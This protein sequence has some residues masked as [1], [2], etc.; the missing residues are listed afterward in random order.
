MLESLTESQKS[1]FPTYANKWI[2]FGNAPVARDFYNEAIIA[3][4]QNTV[5]GMYSI[6]KKNISANKVYLAGSPYHAAF[7]CAAL[8]VGKPGVPAAPKKAKLQNLGICEQYINS[9][10]NPEEIIKESKK[11]LGIRYW[12]RIYAGFYAML[13]FFRE[14]TELKNTVFKKYEREYVYGVLFSAFCYDGFFFKDFA[15][16]SKCPVIVAPDRLEWADGAI[17]KR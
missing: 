6:T 13:D 8:I 1:K 16:A 9:F 4:I 3:Q 12:G 7:M 15:V 11:V 10:S 2:E 17:V 5:V 14:E